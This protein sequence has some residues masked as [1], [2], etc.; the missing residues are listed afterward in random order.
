M[1]YTPRQPDE[2]INVSKTHPLVEAGTLVLGLTAFFVIATILLVYLVEIMLRLVSVETETRW[3]AGWVPDDVVAIEDEDPRTTQ[4]RALLQRLTTHW[5]DANYEF[6]LNVEESD[7]PN[8]MALPGGLIIVTTALLDSV[9]TENELAFVLGHELGHFR[10]RD[11]IRQ[12]GRAT[13]LS[14]F[15]TA[16]TQ[17]SSS[18]NF[19]FNI[20]DLTLRNFSREQESEADQFGL[21][22]VYAEYGHV[23]DA[24]RFFDRVS[25]I[26]G[27]GGML[28]DYLDTHPQPDSR[29]DALKAYARANGWPLEGQLREWTA[30]D[31]L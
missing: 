27:D 2:G 18:G 17:G 28:R 22:I 6:R 11:H 13:V 7:M 10:N 25:D 19:G 1:R 3:F 26:V 4:T 29:I 16:I 31:T 12:L 14:L 24:W 20:T 30:D 9:E 23:N 15:F 21:S 5:A 8:A